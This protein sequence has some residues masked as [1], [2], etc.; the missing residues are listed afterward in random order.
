MQTFFI[1]KIEPFR[2]PSLLPPVAFPCLAVNSKSIYLNRYTFTCYILNVTPEKKGKVLSCLQAISYRYQKVTVEPQSPV[3][4][5]LSQ[6]DHQFKLPVLMYLIHKDHL[7]LPDLMHFFY[8]D[9]ERNQFWCTIFVTITYCYQFW[10]FFLTIFTAI[11][12]ENLPAGPDRTRSLICPNRNFE[13]RKKLMIVIYNIFFPKQNEFVCI[14]GSC[15]W[16]LC[17]VFK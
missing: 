4:I 12:A 13:K 5:H 15:K 2:S 17:R 16:V 14:F 1:C 3:L 10:C 6:Y 8:H 11:A 7:K 9:T